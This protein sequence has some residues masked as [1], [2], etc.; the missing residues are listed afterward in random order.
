MLSESD[1]LELLKSIVGISISSLNIDRKIEEII[2][3]SEIYHP[4]FQFNNS[5]R[6]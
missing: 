3:S 2:H 4:A 6:E 1:A 5:Y